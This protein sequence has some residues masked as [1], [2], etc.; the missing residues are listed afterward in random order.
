MEPLFL[1]TK[2]NSERGRLISP[3]WIVFIAFP[4]MDACMHAL[5]PTSPALRQGLRHRCQHSS[6]C[7]LTAQLNLALSGKICSFIVLSKLQPPRRRALTSEQIRLRWAEI[8]YPNEIFK[9]LTLPVFSQSQ[10]VLQSL[11][12]RIS[13]RQLRLYLVICNR[14]LLIIAAWKP[15][16]IQQG[17]RIQRNAQRNQNYRC[18]FKPTLKVHYNSVTLILR[19]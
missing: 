11:S 18:P 14:T 2:L 7:D 10:T 12:S 5:R 9:P 17:H 1:P 19:W 13:R 15:V 4:R 16:R 8:T 3:F 6:C